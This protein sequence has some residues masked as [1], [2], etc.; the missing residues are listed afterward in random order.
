[1]RRRVW[2]IVTVCFAVVVS[3]ACDGGTTSGSS[4]ISENT[5]PASPSPQPTASASLLTGNVYAIVQRHQWVPIVGAAVRILDGPLAGTE[6]LTN[7]GGTYSFA[8]LPIRT[9]TV[10]VAQP[11]YRVAVA[12]AI[13]PTDGLNFVLLRDEQPVQRISVGE[14]VRSTVSADDPRC[15]TGDPH[16][17]ELDAPCTTFQFTSPRAGILVADLVWSG[18][19]IYMELLTP[20]LG[21]CCSSPLHLQFAVTSGVTYTL[22]VGFHGTTG[23][24]PKGRAAFELTTS[25]T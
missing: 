8:G 16:V 13:I 24:G 19:G 12:T 21:K 17:E 23:A 1:M 9:V 4:P 5:S 3:L 6:V 25:V 10:E 15:D 14:T 11:G 22:S 20:T 18:S 7:T 2:V